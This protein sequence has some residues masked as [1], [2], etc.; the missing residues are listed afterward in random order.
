MVL[1]NSDPF[2]PSCSTL[3]AHEYLLPR[4]GELRRLYPDIE[5]ELD[6]RDEMVDLLAEGVDIAVRVGHLPDSSL[7]A[8]RVGTKRLGWLASPAYLKRRGTPQ[9]PEELGQHSCLVY[10]GRQ[11]QLDLWRFCDAR[12]VIRELK[13]QAAISCSDSR[14]LLELALAGEGIAMGDLLLARRYLQQGLLLQVLEDWHH[15]ESLPVHLLC[16]GRS[17]RSRAA[18]AVWDQLAQWLSADLAGEPG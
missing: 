3:L 10:K 7:L 18:E 9:T 8:R 13:V 17:S 15:P 12:G 16:L 11:L 1:I 2:I 5:L 4:I 14:S 6:I